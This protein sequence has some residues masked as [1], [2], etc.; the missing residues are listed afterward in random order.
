[1]NDE[2]DIR[3]TVLQVLKGQSPDY[4]IF[5]NASAFAAEELNM[6]EVAQVLDDLYQENLLER[7]IWLDESNPDEIVAIPGGYRLKQSPVQGSETES[8]ETGESE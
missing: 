3:E 6:D 4:F 8:R 7:E 2:H 1:M 5:P